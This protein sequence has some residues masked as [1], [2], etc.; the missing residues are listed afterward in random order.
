MTL[1]LVIIDDGA[2][3]IQALCIE[4][5]AQR[6]VNCL[7]CLHAVHI[8]AYSC[9]HW[10]VLLG[11][12]QHLSNVKVSTWQRECSSF[13]ETSLQRIH[14]NIL[15]IAFRVSRLGRSQD[16]DMNFTEALDTGA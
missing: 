11:P 10:P 5:L 8:N 1:T 3:Q 4:P 12:L 9:S 13:K 6:W 15:Q 2:F 16:P 14:P 7:Y